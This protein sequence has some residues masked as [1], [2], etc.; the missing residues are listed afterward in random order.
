MSLLNHQ[1]DVTKK[2]YVDAPVTAPVQHAEPLPHATDVPMSY[3]DDRKQLV[4]EPFDIIANI[5]IEPHE[6]ESEQLQGAEF[7]GA[8][9]L[10]LE[11]TAAM[12]TIY[13]HRDAGPLNEPEEYSDTTPETPER[14][15]RLLQHDARAHKHAAHITLGF[16]ALLLL[17]K[18]PS[19][20]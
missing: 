15:T 19:A 3:V 11:V 10:D 9:P 17:V 7:I 13:S 8:E 1:G 18:Q 5:H 6:D 16:L 2:I 20:Q 14:L 4:N 12:E